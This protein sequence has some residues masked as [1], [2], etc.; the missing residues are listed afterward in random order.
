M[1][2]QATCPSTRPSTRVYAACASVILSTALLGSVLAGF[3]H[4]A[5][6]NMTTAAAAAQSSN[7]SASASPAPL[8]LAGRSEL[9]AVDVK[10]A[11]QALLGTSR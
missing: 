10:A 11:E 6:R 4:L 9:Q 3:D 7:R 2:T 5:G 8:L 1:H